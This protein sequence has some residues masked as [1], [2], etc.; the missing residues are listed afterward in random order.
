MA[1]DGDGAGLAGLVR[2]RLDQR[3]GQPH[4]VV[5]VQRDQAHLQRERPQAVA[6][7]LGLALHQAEA[8]VADEVR[9]RLGRGHA[10][11]RGQVFQRERA[12]VVG[13]RAQQLAAHLD[14]LDAA[15]RGRWLRGRQA[16]LLR[17]WTASGR[18]AIIADLVQR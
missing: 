3:R 8:A 10:G 9:M 2:E 12:A 4:R 18:L 13:E 1:P 11:G 17:G 15:G 7:R 6:A 14:A 5:L 16:G